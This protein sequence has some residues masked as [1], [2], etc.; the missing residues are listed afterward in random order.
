MIE[1]KGN[2]VCPKCGCKIE[3]GYC[4]CYNNAENIEVAGITVR[5][6]NGTKLEVVKG[7]L[8]TFDDEGNSNC[9]SLNV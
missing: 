1:V 6:T 3:G 8:I 5:Y 7:C 2:N 4:E 9:T